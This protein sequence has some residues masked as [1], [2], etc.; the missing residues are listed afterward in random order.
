MR[1]LVSRVFWGLV[2]V[3]IGLTLI[4]EAI[5]P[6]DVPTTNIILA[7][8]LIYIGICIF[9]PKSSNIKSNVHIHTKNASRKAQ[10]VE[11]NE[12]SSV[13]GNNVIDLT[14]YRD[15]SK[16]VQINT[17][18]GTSEVLLN[19]DEHY[20]FATN[21]VFGHTILPNR[22]TADNSDNDESKINIYIDT[23]FGSTTVLLVKVEQEQVV[24]EVPERNEE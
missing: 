11:I 7:F 17:V 13:F 18:F 19:E 24:E 3:F 9:T 4:L 2:L 10:G 8:I 6:I 14:K 21:T 1:F 15:K 23:V 22:Y 16:P 12:Y 20:F 5:F